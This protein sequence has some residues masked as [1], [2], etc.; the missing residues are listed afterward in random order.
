MT[1]LAPKDPEAPATYSIDF[2]NEVIRE[3][4]R[5]YDFSAG[6]VVRPQFGTGF[7]YECQT[8]GRTAAHYPN[9]WP[10]AEGQTVQDGSVVWVAREPSDSGLPSISDA[11][12]TL[13]DGLTL[14][15][16]SQVGLV[17]FVTVS[18]GVDGVDYDVLCRMTPSAGNII[19]Q[20]ITIPVRSQ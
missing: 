13:P 9:R 10:R 8:A 16:Q 4:R 12:W 11:D 18:G 6:Q 1:T 3:A 15:S 5:D 7:Y 2:H 20:T 19:E 14:D 17:A